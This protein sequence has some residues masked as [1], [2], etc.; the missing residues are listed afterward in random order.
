MKNETRYILVLLLA[1]FIIADFTFSFYQHYSKPLDGDLPG[2]IVPAEDV[3]PVLADPIGY[4]VIVEGKTY[5]NPNRYFSHAFFYLWFDSVPFALMEFMDPIES[6]YVASAIFKI[7]IQLWLVIL[8]AAIVY[9]NYFHRWKFILAAA[10]ILPFFQINGF[11]SEIGIIDS[12]I[13]YVFFYAFPLAL[14][15]LYFLHLFRHLLYNENLPKH[16]SFDLMRIL[17]AFPVALSGPLN[18]GIVLVISLLIIVDNIRRKIIQNDA[19]VFPKAVFRFLLPV[20]LLSIYSLYL[21]TFNSVNI[22]NEK[23]LWEMYL[24]LAKGIFNEV[25]KNLGLMTLVFLVFIQFLFLF[26][27]DAWKSNPKIRASFYSILIFSAVYVFLLPFGGYRGARPEILR[28]DTLMPITVGLIFLFCR[29]AFLMLEKQ[30]EIKMK[31]IAFLSGAVLLFTLKDFSRFESNR[32]ERM[33]L[34]QI[35]NSEKEVIILEEKS[36]VISWGPLVEREKSII[37]GKM[38]Y[39]YGITDEPKEFY[40][41]EVAVEVK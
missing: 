2:G 17:L 9:E 29:S 28:Y 21:G 10:L 20:V 33:A 13:T 35:S 31:Y 3:R 1:I 25:T 4:S 37:V 23:P 30:G 15:L 38:L 5:A 11:Q 24:R 18:P 41:S 32:L 8:I 6:L 39:K 16:R 40:Y 19:Y 14:L 34:F 27:T 7:V 12:S 26:F 36:G 22:A